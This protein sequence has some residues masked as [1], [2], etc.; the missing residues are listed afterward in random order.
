MRIWKEQLLLRSFDIFHPLKIHPT[1]VQHALLPLD[2]L[3]KGVVYHGVDFIP[4]F[5]LNLSIGY[6]F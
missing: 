6:E 3:Y 5:L 2:S 1:R 4:L